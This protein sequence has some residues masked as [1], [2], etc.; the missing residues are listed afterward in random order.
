M[1]FFGIDSFSPVT[2][3]RRL[4]AALATDEAFQLLDK[5][6]GLEDTTWTAGGCLLLADMLAKATGGQKVAIYDGETGIRIG[7]PEHIAVKLGEMYLDGDG[8]ST[9]ASLIDRWRREEGL[10]NPVI[11]P[12]NAPDAKRAGFV[13]PKPTKDLVTFINRVVQG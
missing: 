2:L 10:G 9:E 4:K 6:R 7:H 3:G 8:A 5:Q 13:L 11:A 1:S 12:Y